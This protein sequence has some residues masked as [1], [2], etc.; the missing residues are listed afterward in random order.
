MKRPKNFQTDR[1]HWFGLVKQILSFLSSESKSL[2]YENDAKN[3]ETVRKRTAKRS[4]KCE[5]GAME[6]D[7]NATE[8]IGSLNWFFKA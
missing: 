6:N 4:T 2:A 5:V 7:Q 8:K 3:G 1:R